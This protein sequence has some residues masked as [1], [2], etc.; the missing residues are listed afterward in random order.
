V[1]V[2]G[3]NDDVTGVK[4][5]ADSNMTAVTNN[6][7]G[8]ER[9]WMWYLDGPFSGPDTLTISGTINSWGCGA[10]LLALSGTDPGVAAFGNA[11][12]ASIDFTTTSDES[13]VVAG[14]TVNG[15]IYPYGVSPLT[16]Y[17]SRDTGSSAGASAVKA[18]ST[19]GTQTFTF[20]GNTTTPSLVIAEFV[21]T[22]PPAGMV[23]V[24]R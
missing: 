21:K 16:T 5:G 11:S 4:W 12:S 20:T 14:Y 24:I 19:I 8:G 2:M 9:V 7:N 6:F 17:F 10:A 3:E 18:N 23:I 15:G 13:F 1:I 22:P